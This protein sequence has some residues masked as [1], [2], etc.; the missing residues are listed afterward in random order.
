M[1]PNDPPV[2]GRDPFQ[3]MTQ[4]AVSCQSEC[5]Q[6]HVAKVSHYRIPVTAEQKRLVTSAAEAAGQDMAAWARVRLI[7]AAMSE[8]K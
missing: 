3:I 4:R 1:W 2:R 7:T 6:E 5:R 8:K